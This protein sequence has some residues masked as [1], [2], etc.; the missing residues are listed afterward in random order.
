VLSVGT[1]E[2]IVMTLSDSEYEVAAYYFPNYH[3]D[4]RNE[5]VH[6]KGWSEWDLVRAARPRFRG[7]QQ[8]KVPAQGYQDESDPRVFAEKI[9]LAARH[10]I[11]AFIFDWYF[12]D[13]GPFLERALDAGYLR[14]DNKSQLKFALMWANHDWT[15][16]HPAKL[17][18][19]SPVLHRGAVTPATFERMTDHVIDRYFQEPSYWK[20]D[21]EPYFSVYDVGRLID[22]FGG[23]EATATA[24]WRFKEKV[25]RAG[26]PGLHLNAVA[27]GINLLSG[28]SRLAAE[29]PLARLG[30][31]SVTSYT[32][33]HDQRLVGFP[34]APYQKLAAGAPNVWKTLSRKY[35]VPYHPN[36]TMG[37]DPSPRTTASDPLVKGAPYPFTAI[38]F[39]NEPDRFRAALVQARSFLSRRRG[40][41][42]LTINA[43][44]EWTEGSYLEPDTDHGLAYLKA[45]RQV[46]KATRHPRPKRAATVA[47]A[48]LA[49]IL[50][51]CG[52]NDTKPDTE[53]MGAAQ[54]TEGGTGGAVVGDAGA[55]GFGGRSDGGTAGSS[56]AGRGGSDGGQAGTS[57]GS[58]GSG[59]GGTVGGPV[60]TGPAYYIDNRSGSNCSDA[61][62]GTSPTAPWCTFD[63]VNGK[64]LVA[65]EQILLARGASFTETLRP[66]GSGTSSDW[67]S[68][69]AYGVGARP[70]IRGNDNAADRTIILKDPDYFSLA[71]LEISNAGE[72]ILIDYTSLGHAGL[73]FRN[74]YVHDVSTTMDRKPLQSDYP[75]IQ[76]S[77]AITIGADVASP[78][79][80]QWVVKDITV[81]GLEAE[82]TQ[83]VYVLCGGGL[84]TPVDYSTFPPSSVRN[85]VV[86]NSYFHTM[87]AP[88][89]CLES[90]QDSYFYSNRIDCSGHRAEPQGT[91]CFFTWLMTNVVI[92]NSTLDNMSDTVSNDESALDLEGYLDKISV[93]GNYF[94]NNAGCA[95]EYLQLGRNGDYHT[96]NEVSGNAF[97]SNGTGYGMHGTSL[98]EVTFTGNHPSG[99]I[100]DNLYSERNGLVSGYSAPIFTGFTLTNNT[101]VAPTNLYNAPTGFSGTKGQN[102]WSYQTFSGSSFSDMTAYD[103][104]TGRWTSG[105][106]YVDRFNQLPGGCANCGVARTWTAKVA[107]TISIRG[108]VFKNDPSGAEGVKV[109]IVQNSTTI[110]PTT[111]VAT[112]LGASDLSGFDANLDSVNVAVGDQIRFAVYAGSSS[113]GN[114]LTSWAPTI[115]R[116]TG[117]AGCDTAGENGSV[118]LSCPTGK[119]ITEIVFA[120][121]GTPT[122]TCGGYAVGSCNAQSS[123]SVVESRC[124][125]QASCTVPASAATFGDPCV[126]T[127][128]S[129]TVQIVCGP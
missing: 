93:R 90:M 18:G 110:W 77:A 55:H 116:S 28:E 39:G 70:I 82:S 117:N 7:H 16:I 125:G 43:W 109:A 17:A 118:N 12:Y 61:G 22:G 47:T 54:G 121:Y 111:G 84:L 89:F 107:G 92:A 11:S 100:R 67:I 2:G 49:A 129:L 19:P 26:L 122:G 104:V 14:A 94:S 91:T 69:D 87:P 53:D 59:A 124:L 113:S 71:N 48:V 75:G 57:T 45:V 36:V 3:A 27:F 112:A 34:A 4:P 21:G 23:I 115:G 9:S 20:I 80:S 85:V 127:A 5:A 74:I 15:D 41:K 76:N 96:N 40:N 29:A 25:R 8:P 126:G 98:W 52:S 37:W 83:G 72:G 62:P 65:G 24:L 120:S 128:K 106:G 123:R 95:I 73:Q 99:T 51:A 88:G 31:D 63:K 30:I 103:A 81:D 86:K 79:A 44:N 33:L 78:S 35:G 10:G 13:D 50:A 102:Q 6:G 42:I 97:V 108:R 64:T 1:E 101:P 114:D 105:G 38:A 60:S 58:G 66:T 32:W 119:A 46:F 56:Q 68:V